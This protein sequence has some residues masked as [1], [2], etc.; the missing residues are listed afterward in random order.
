[1]RAEP[2]LVGLLLA[3]VGHAL[4]VLVAR[5]FPV[6]LL[7]LEVGGGGVEEKPVHFEVQQVGDLE[8]RL[9]GQA[10]LDGEQVVHRPV[11]GLLVYLAEPVDVDILGDPPGGGKLGGGGQG[12]VGGQREQHPLHLRVE[13]A[14]GQ[15]PADHLVQAQAAPDP[16]QHVGAAQ[17]PG[18]ADRQLAGRGGCT[19][20]AGSSSRDSAATSRLDRVL[21]QLVLAAEGVQDLGPDTPAAASHSL[22]ASCRYRMTCDLVLREDAFTYTAR[23]YQGTD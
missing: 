11:A 4:P 1:M 3:A 19:A 15:L 21:V 8:V 2:G 12:A 7:S 23:T 6:G 13:P 17:R 20:P 16:V 9:P 10:G 5:H 18:T 14:A 22:W